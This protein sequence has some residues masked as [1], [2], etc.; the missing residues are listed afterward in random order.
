MREEFYQHKRRDRVKWIFT[1]VA[2]FLA[3]VMLIA[4]CMQIFGNEKLKPENWFKKSEQTQPETPPEENGGAVVSDNESHGIKL[5][6][7]R[8]SPEEFV[9]YGITPKADSVIQITAV[10]TPVNASVQDIE[11]T[12]SWENGSSEWASG[13]NIEDYYAFASYGNLLATA[14]CYQPF[15]E[16][17]RIIATSVDNPS[18]SATATANYV[19][20]INPSFTLL[21]YA[22]INNPVEVTGT[23][24]AEYGYVFELSEP[25]ADGTVAG[26]VKYSNFKETV[27]TVNGDTQII[28]DLE[29]AIYNE[30][31]STKETND[32]HMDA[33]NF[34]Y[35]GWVYTESA[36]EEII[37]QEGDYSCSPGW[38]FEC[39][40]DAGKKLTNGRITAAK[41]N[42]LYQKCGKDKLQCTVSLDY[43]YTYNGVT[44]GEGTISKTYVI[45][46]TPLGVA[47]SGMTLNKTILNH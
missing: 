21:D 38:F 15:G 40:S 14:V 19:K 2:L 47:V 4:L 23:L 33:C 42:Q 27:T 16:P 5:M 8:L 3:F 46:C 44:F 35:N 39:M 22:D 24:L 17:V 29:D 37:T 36:L 20:R 13:K 25:Y 12:C 26:T 32:P 30:Y 31:N 9:S 34:L 28:G 41:G 6:S 10:I 18:V 43:K 1:F 11:W 45:D 7:K